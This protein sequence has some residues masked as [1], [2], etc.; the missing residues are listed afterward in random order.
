[1]TLEF[2][3]KVSSNEIFYELMNRSKTGCA[4]TIFYEVSGVL[5]Y[6]SIDHMIKRCHVAT[7]SSKPAISE[8]VPQ[9]TKDLRTMDQKMASNKCIKILLEEQ[10]K[11]Q[12]KG[13]QKAEEKAK[14]EQPQVIQDPSPEKREDDKDGKKDPTQVP[15]HERADNEMQEEKTK[16]RFQ[17]AMRPETLEK[18]KAEDHAVHKVELS[19]K[20]VYKITVSKKETPT[21]NSKGSKED[22]LSK[23]KDEKDGRWRK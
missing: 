15:S 16:E 11:K 18:W 6:W 7:C 20:G 23:Q 2:N 5:V 21:E 3:K 1:M 9:D 8:S 17:I 4:Q 19:A 12:A 13:E 14:E 22:L 10:K